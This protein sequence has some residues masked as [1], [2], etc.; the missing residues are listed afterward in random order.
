MASDGDQGAVPDDSRGW[1][2]VGDHLDGEP[3]GEAATA[4]GRA[5]EQADVGGVSAERGEVACRGQ[6]AVLLDPVDH[7]VRVGEPALGPFGFPARLPQPGQQRIIAV[8]PVPGAADSGR[9]VGG[10]GGPVPRRSED[11]VFVDAGDSGAGARVNS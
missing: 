3:R 2:S 9:E 1:Q 11:L 7:A 4:G 8:Q 10:V 5:G 6:A